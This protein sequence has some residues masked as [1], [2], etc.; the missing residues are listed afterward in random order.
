MELNNMTLSGFT[1][2]TISSSPAPGG[3][4]VAALLGSLAASLSGMVASLTIGKKGYED[5]QSTMDA[6]LKEAEELRLSLLEAIDA[7]AGSFHGY[8]KALKL[9]KD[10]E[11][12]KQLRTATLQQELKTATLVPL[13]T[14]RLSAKVFPLALLAV[15]QGNKN[16]LSDGLVSAMCAR[17]AILSA[18]L[19]VKINLLSIKDAAFVEAMNKEVTALRQYAAL[20][21]QRILS[22]SKELTE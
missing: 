11:E 14:A 22:L 16:A 1:A 7:D 12:Q 13:E 17:T 18:L 6:M 20:Q 8:M 5:R 21:E 10:T 15:E 9:P 3:G 19:N 2:E 4:A